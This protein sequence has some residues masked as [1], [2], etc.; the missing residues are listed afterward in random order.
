M[1]PVFSIAK[2][3]QAK[4]VIYADGEDERVLRAAQVVL[5]EG[6]AEPILIGRPHVVDV[7]A[8][9]LRPAHQARAPISS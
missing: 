2:G 6:I 3:A 9:T 4:R 1:K 8:E 7:T 5:E